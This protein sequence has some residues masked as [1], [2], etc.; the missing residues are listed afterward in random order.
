MIEVLLTISPL[1]VL[2]ALLMVGVPV[3]FALFASGTLGLLIVTGFTPTVST[4]MSAVRGS[5]ANYLLST[6]PLFIL[7]A[8][9]ISRSGISED[10]FVAMRHWFGHLK[11]GLPIATTFANGIFAA[12]SGSS[13]AAAATMSKIAVPEMKRYGYSNELSLGTVTA[14]GTFAIMIPPSAGL[15]IYGVLTETSIA[16]LFMGGVLP[17]V[18][19]LFGYVVVILVWERSG[20]A[21]RLPRSNLTKRVNS[22]KPVW[23][24]LIIIVAVLGG[25]YAGVVTPTEA[26]ALGAMIALLVG[27]PLGMNRSEVREAVRETTEIS[28]MLFIILIGAQVFNY[29]LANSGMVTALLTAVGELAVPALV[30][31]LIIFLF[32]ILLGMMMDLLAMLILTLPVTFPLVVSTLGFNPIWFGVVLVK[33]GEIGLVSPPFGLNA[34]VTASTIDADIS[35]TFRGAAPFIVADIVVVLLMLAFPSI[36]LWLPNTI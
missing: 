14:S 18:L 31:L 5:S 29:Y 36:V 30:I 4:M 22:L 24:V 2:V 15:I 19:T 13:T 7:M 25:L 35:E 33:L 10:L 12:V 27:I 11:G 34:Y 21:E 26:G 9:F 3:A 20:G 8:E 28:A 6:V 1:F 23:P 17:G 16:R 32:Y